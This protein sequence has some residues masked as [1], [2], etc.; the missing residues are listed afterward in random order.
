MISVP[1]ALGRVKRITSDLNHGLGLYTSRA[2]TRPGKSNSRRGPVFQQPLPITREIAVVRQ[3]SL[4][5][6]AQSVVHVEP[7]RDPP[8]NLEFLFRLDARCWLAS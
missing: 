6:I 1:V 4:D 2:R 3:Q 8:H 5:G 7:R